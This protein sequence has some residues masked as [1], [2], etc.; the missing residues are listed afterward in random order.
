MLIHTQLLRILPGSGPWRFISI[1]W[2]DGSSTRW[3]SITRLRLQ[4]FLVTWVQV[5]NFLKREI[6]I[7]DYDGFW[8][9][10]WWC[11]FGSE[12]DCCICNSPQQTICAA[13]SPNNI[14]GTS[15][16][17]ASLSATSSDTARARANKR[18]SAA[19]SSA[20]NAKL[21]N[22]I[23]HKLVQKVSPKK[24]DW[25]PSRCGFTKARIAKTNASFCN[26]WLRHLPTSVI[27]AWTSYVIC[28]PFNLSIFTIQP[29]DWSP[30]LALISWTLPVPMVPKEFG[31]Q[32]IPND[33]S[34]GCR[35][36][37][38]ASTI[39]HFLQHLQ[40]K[41]LPALTY[42]YMLFIVYMFIVFG[43]CNVV[44]LWKKYTRNWESFWHRYPGT[45]RTKFIFPVSSWFC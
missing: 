38:V 9:L 1:W 30:V 39:H 36:S 12:S 3:M 24:V 19:S 35:T 8:D 14:R 29:S 18:D 15:S 21:R 11:L 43:C 44:D 2:T 33:E 28:N 17:A 42:M 6:E 40:S 34:S 10:D 4:Y 31:K 7:Q 27:S 37:L 20:S 23:S 45:W 41:I 26:T 25:D 22:N 32:R 13:T 5:A 16:M